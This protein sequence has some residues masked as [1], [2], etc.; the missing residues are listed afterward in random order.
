MLYVKKS[1]KEVLK[2]S[3]FNL[4]EN[5][6]DHFVDVLAD[7]FELFSKLEEFND[8]DVEPLFKIHEY[9]NITY[10]DT[11]EK[12]AVL[13]NSKFVENNFYTV[14]KVRS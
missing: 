1:I 7:F 6:M 13:L 4:E 12:Q 11:L 9:G 2:M 10:N 8:V 5:E 3:K 14:P